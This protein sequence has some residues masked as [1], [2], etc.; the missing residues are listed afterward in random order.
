[1]VARNAHTGYIFSFCKIYN[2]DKD[3][4]KEMEQLLDDTEKLAEDLMDRFNPEPTLVG[5]F[6]H[7]VLMLPE[8]NLQNNQVNRR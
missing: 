8:R 1:M 6:K 7:A 4:R 5:V 3:L 2:T